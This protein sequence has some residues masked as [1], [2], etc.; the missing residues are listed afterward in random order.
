MAS[1][2]VVGLGEGGSCAGK[3]AGN[4]WPGAGGRLEWNNM[5]TPVPVSFERF[6]QYLHLLAR[7]NLDA[8]LRSRIEPSDLV[9]QT[10]LN[11]HAKRD[12]LRGRRDEEVVAW[13]RQILA[14]NL[15]DA[16]RALGRQKRNMNLERSLEL[17][18]TDS[19]SRVECW[20]EAMQTSVTGKAVRNEQLV[21]LAQAL[22]E[23]P[24]GQRDAIELHHLQGCSLVETAERMSRTEGAI[25]GLLRRGLRSLRERMT[26][27]GIRG[28]A[29]GVRE[30]GKSTR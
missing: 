24:E 18:I 15:A 20:L 10:L 14:R 25:A 17:A 3:G 16:V 27:E 23:L 2:L 26:E 22:A 28:Q 6:R 11:A 5:D 4:G 1:F 7:A 29:S 9:Q 30:E 8:R 13:L 21:R 19:F 12:Q